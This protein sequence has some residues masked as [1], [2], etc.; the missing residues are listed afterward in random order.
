MSWW[1]SCLVSRWHQRKV[2]MVLV[3]GE[4]A[5]GVTVDQDEHLTP[6]VDP[7]TC[8]LRSSQRSWALGKAPTRAAISCCLAA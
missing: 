6:K 1:I 3:E 2:R 5:D 4:H 7:A 8:P